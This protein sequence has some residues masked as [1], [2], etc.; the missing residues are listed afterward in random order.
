MVEADRASLVAGYSGQTS[1]KTTAV[2]ESALGGV[3][4]VD[5]AYALV[6]DTKVI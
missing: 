2:V 1:L 5:E 3:L 4:F 6:S